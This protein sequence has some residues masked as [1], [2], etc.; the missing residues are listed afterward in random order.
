LSVST[1]REPPFL[2][3]PI[4]FSTAGI[5]EPRSTFLSQAFPF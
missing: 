4:F 2:A 3:P 1:L 5:A